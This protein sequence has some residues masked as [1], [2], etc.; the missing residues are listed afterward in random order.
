MNLRWITC[1]HVLC[2]VVSSSRNLHLWYLIYS[3]VYYSVLLAVY[4][5]ACLVHT[6]GTS[7]YVG[8]IVSTLGELDDIGE[9]K[10]DSDR[11]ITTAAAAPPQQQQQQ[12]HNIYRLPYHIIQKKVSQVSRTGCEAEQDPDYSSRRALTYSSGTPRKPYVPLS[13]YLKTTTT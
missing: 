3:S 12:Q 10:E 7:T 13:L 5:Y 2:V 11:K 8:I 9:E 4:L 1:M 6:P